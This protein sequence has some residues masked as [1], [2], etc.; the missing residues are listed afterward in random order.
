M[1]SRNSSH[2]NLRKKSSS[3]A[4][5][6]ASRSQSAEYIKPLPPDTGDVANTDDATDMNQHSPNLTESEYQSSAGGHDRVLW[7]HQMNGSA[8][9]AVTPSQRSSGGSLGWIVAAPIVIEGDGGVEGYED[10]GQEGE[11]QEEVG[12]AEIQAGS[13]DLD[14]VESNGSR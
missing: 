14:M 3:T 5:A 2:V 9:E 12:E 6:S 11:A 4:T 1:A 10:K 13:V 7:G 8:A